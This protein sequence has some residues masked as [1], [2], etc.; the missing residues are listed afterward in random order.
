MNVDGRKIVNNNTTL[1]DQN[2]IYYVVRKEMWA[3]FQVVGSYDSLDLSSIGSDP[4]EMCVLLSNQKKK[5]DF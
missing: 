3:Q 1:S 2:L 4:V 5:L